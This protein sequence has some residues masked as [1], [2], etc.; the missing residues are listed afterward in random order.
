MGVTCSSCSGPNDRQ[1]QRYC[2]SC[3]AAY[4]RTH[5]PK[6]REL[7]E[8]AR[9]KANCR[10]LTNHWVRQGVVIK[11]AC[12]SCGDPESQAHHEDYN[13]PINV[14]WF[15]RKYHLEHHESHVEQS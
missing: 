14:K 13:D 9:K 10:A 8:E 5:R 4:M 3:H 7:S 2:T 15:C 12:K 6:H 11:E 1:P